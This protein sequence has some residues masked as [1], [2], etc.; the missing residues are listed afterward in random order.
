MRLLSA[1]QHWP[2]PNDFGSVRSTSQPNN[3]KRE[4]RI[5]LAVITAQTTALQNQR[6]A[7]NLLTRRL[8]AGVVLI[9]AWEWMGCIGT[10]GSSEQMIR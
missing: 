10:S 3:T 9:E 1:T 2:Q 4:R 6:T 5:N 8:T 7:A